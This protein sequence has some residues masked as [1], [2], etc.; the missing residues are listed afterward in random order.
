MA[1][2]EESAP[3][4]NVLLARLTGDEESEELG[5]LVSIDT[6]VLRE[7]HTHIVFD[8]FVG[9][10]EPGLLVATV[11]HDAED[12]LLRRRVGTVFFQN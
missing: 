9:E 2:C 11:E 7:E 5:R 4:A 8:V 1:C 12:V 6:L 3:F 10:A